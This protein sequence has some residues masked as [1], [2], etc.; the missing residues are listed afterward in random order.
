MYRLFFCLLFVSVSLGSCVKSNPP[1][2][3]NPIPVVDPSSVIKFGGL[4]GTKSDTVQTGYELVYDGH[5]KWLGTIRGIYFPDPITDSPIVLSLAADNSYSVTLNGQLAMQ[6]TY[7]IDSSTFWN[8]IIFNNIVQPAGDTI[9][10]TTGNITR[11]CFNY[12]E[13]GRLTIFRNNEISVS[14]DTLTLLRTPITPETP[15]SLFKRIN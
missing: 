7:S 1:L 2:V 5:W 4:N 11:L 12:S 14:G 6:G 9:S 15:V 8:N 10:I 13:I 3:I